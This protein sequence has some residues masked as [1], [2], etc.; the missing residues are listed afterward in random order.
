MARQASSNI[1][2]SAL[3]EGDTE[4]N[5]WRLGRSL[6]HPLHNLSEPLVFLQKLHLHE[7]IAEIYIFVICFIT[8]RVF[9]TLLVFKYWGKPGDKNLYHN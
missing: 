4:G 7:S 1:E 9:V 5:D 8:W 2:S 6:L 3:L